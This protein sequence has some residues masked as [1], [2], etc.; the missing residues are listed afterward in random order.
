MK[1][2]FLGCLGLGALGALGVTG[3]LVSG[4]VA[5]GRALDGA[6]GPDHSL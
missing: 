3:L 1:K 6:C 4:V 2:L 5:V